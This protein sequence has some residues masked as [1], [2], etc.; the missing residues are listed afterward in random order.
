[1]NS[2]GLF[3]PASSAPATRW[4]RLYGSALS[5]AIAEYAA[6]ADELVVVIGSNPAELIQLESELSWLLDE[7]TPVITIPDW[8]TLPYDHFSPH[9]DIV[10]QRLKTLHRLPRTTR[11][12]LLIPVQMLLQR[13]SPVNYLQANVLLLSQGQNVAIGE[14]RDNLVEAG[15]RHV[16]QVLEHGEF[17]QRG[18]ILD[19][20]PM[21]S[22]QPVRVDFFDEEV[23]SIRVFDPETQLSTD[24]LDRIELLPAH[25]FP[26]NEA[27]ITR[28]RQAFP[29][30]NLFHL[31]SPAYFIR[32]DLELNAA[33]T[34]IKSLIR[35]RDQ[36]GLYL[37]P[38]KSLTQKAEVIFRSEPTFW[39]NPL[40]NCHIDCGKEVPLSIYTPAELKRLVGYSR[41]LL[42]DQGF[43]TPRT[44]LASGWLASQ[45]VLD[46]ISAH[47][48]LYDF[49]A[50]PPALVKRRLGEYPIFEWLNQRWHY[51]SVYSQPHLLPTQT[52]DITEIGLSAGVVDF[53]THEEITMLF[54]KYA[55][56]QRANPHRSLVFTL[57][58]HQE[59]AYQFI[60]RLQRSLENIYAFALENGTM[61]EPL[62][63]P[64]PKLA[65]LPTGS[66]I[67]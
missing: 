27:G 12:V 9:R 47:H 6:S 3:F 28:F 43:E 64:R 48:F 57:G 38:W 13:L 16:E 10:S 29:D 8:E 56:K 36:V 61:V 18:S 21:T 59:T 17:A 1:M 62:E 40:K 55:E 11:G 32:P 30:L 22:D 63:L 34:K 7:S 52:N 25:E 58:I 67:K 41:K 60:H 33:V 26:L 20:F 23:D 35:P 2:S 51:V 50:I 66:I 14:L 42:T 24:K 15:Y 45:G 31:I 5:L 39:G 19:L 49:S 37:Q 46:A 53:V 54:V 4:G 44:F 65:S